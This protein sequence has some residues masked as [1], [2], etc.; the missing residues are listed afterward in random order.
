MILGHT[1]VVYVAA[2]QAHTARTACATRGWTE[3]A[4]GKYSSEADIVAGLTMH[5]FR[6]KQN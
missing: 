1:S 4:G 2:I 5:D 3:C 6:Q